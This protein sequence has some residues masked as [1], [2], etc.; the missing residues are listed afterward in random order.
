MP[1]YE[2]NSIPKTATLPYITYEVVIGELSEFSTAM[3]AHIWDKTNGLKFL[4]SKADEIGEALL[5]TRLSCD[6]GY[7]KLY[8]GEPFSNNVADS[9]DNTIKGKYMNITA[10]FITL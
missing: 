6:E 8:R 5:N 1:A 4:N 2:E 7:I 9:E 3:V 10:D